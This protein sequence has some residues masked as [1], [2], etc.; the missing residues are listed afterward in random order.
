MTAAYPAPIT[1]NSYARRWGRYQSA[2]IFKRLHDATVRDS[3]AEARPRLKQQY[4][5]V[6]NFNIH[7]AWRD[8]DELLK[9]AGAL[10]EEACGFRGDS[11]FECGVV[12]LT[13]SND[14]DRV[15]TYD[16]LSLAASAQLGWMEAD[17]FRQEARRRKAYIK[18]SDIEALAG[19][20]RLYGFEEER[21]RVIVRVREDVG[22]WSDDELGEPQVLNG[23]TLELDGVDW[24]ADMNRHLRGRKF[25][26]T[27]CR[28]HKPI[29]LRIA[30][31]LP[32]MFPLFEFRDRH[33]NTG[34]IAF[35]RAALLLNVVLR[36]RNFN[37][38]GGA[39]IA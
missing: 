31:R 4:W 26:A 39:I 25:V 20:F 21:R 9:E 22:A 12:D 16:F 19:W 28:Q 13:E 29:D 38:G 30:L 33:D 11:P 14:A 27:L 35:A 17:E 32:P 1:F 18:D 37:C 34:S 5:N 10:L 3:Y 6:F 36:D 7:T 2:H 8:H 23:I 24:L 15:K